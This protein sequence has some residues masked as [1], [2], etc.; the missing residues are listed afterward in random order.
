MTTT[1][2]K[3]KNKTKYKTFVDYY[4]EDPEFRKKHL[5]KLSERIQCECGFVTARCNLSRH[6]KSHVHIDKMEKIN[7]IKVLKE[8]LAQLERETKPKKK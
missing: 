7:R 8:E 4:K 3:T 1:K 2:N 5:E 6:K